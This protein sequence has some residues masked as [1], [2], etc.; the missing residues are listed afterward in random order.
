MPA[1][2]PAQDTNVADMADFVAKYGNETL[3][4]LDEKTDNAAP[5]ER[6]SLPPEPGPETGG[7]EAAEPELD[8][9]TLQALG[10]TPED[11]PSPP[12]DAEGDTAKGPEIDLDLF[13]RHLGVNKDE[14]TLDN[15][16]LKVRT[17]V[18]GE[19]ALTPLSDLRTG[20]QLRQHFTRQNEEFLR[21]K[22]QW[23]QATQQRE[24]Q[25]AQQEQLA[26]EVLKA[27]EQALDAQY[28]RNWDQLRQ[29]DPSE[30][31]A[32]VADYNRKKS[33]LR[34]RQEGI[35]QQHQQRAAEQQQQQYQWAQQQRQKG[36]EYLSEQLGWKDQE[37]F[38]KG[39]ER[40]RGYMQKG[41]NLQPQEIDTILDPRVLIAAE[42]AR[43]YDE[44]QAKIATA[45]KKVTESHKMP[46]GTTP[47]PAGGKRQ[48]VQQSL[49]RLHDSGTVE[50]AADVFKN[51]GIV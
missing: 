37:Q 13:A 31:A 1:P 14:L 29:E 44:L 42:K 21:Q 32:Q 43:Q 4:Q 26:I 28:T 11:P 17:K 45:R 7:E 34:T 25:V 20:Y 35:M 23:E 19:E 50:A 8:A 36:V 46:T 10:L 22:Q 24:S 15:G 3:E 39:A 48:K 18:D 30:Y 51:L 12:G 6:K 38:Q 33:E 49:K 16:E 5:A 41:L 47:K 9:A 27:D 40:L 2:S